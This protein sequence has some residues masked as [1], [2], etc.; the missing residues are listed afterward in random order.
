[1]TFEDRPAKS[2]SRRILFLGVFAALLAVG[3]S[4]VWFYLADRLETTSRAVIASLNHDGVK[5]ECTNSTAR[6]YPFRI[7]IFCEQVSFEDANNGIMASAG[8]FRSAGQIYDPM[9][10]IAELDGPARIDLPQAP[11]LELNWKNLRS[12][13]RLAQPLPQRISVEGQELTATEPG[14]EKRILTAETFEW[15]MRP[16]AADLDLA[17]NFVN[18]ALDPSLVEG[19]ALPPLSSESD[20]TLTNGAQLLLQ[21]VRSMRGQSGTIR[22]LTLT[23]GPETGLALSGPFSIDQDGLIDASLNIAIRDPKG[24]A[25]VIGDILPEY[26]R[27]IRNA[28][29]ALGFLGNAPSIPLTIVKGQASIGFISL[30]SIPPVQP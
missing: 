18:L 14:G 1:M 12:S 8:N 2:Y 5:A 7:G 11:P 15:H 3:Y 22:T 24:I 20:V 28:S 6:G 25:S 23:T 4:G 30:G 13:M 17:G 27:Q 26:R 9:R 21:D 10:L 16:N 29:S 19:R